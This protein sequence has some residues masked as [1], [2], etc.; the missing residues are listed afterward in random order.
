M[1]APENPD[2]IYTLE[3]KEAIELWKK[4]KD[5]WNKWV[6]ENPIAN[7]DFKHKEFTDAYI[8]FEGFNFPAGDIIFSK[9]IFQRKIKT[10]P[11]SHYI[12]ESNINNEYTEFFYDMF[13]TCWVNFKSCK[14]NDGSVY[15]DEAEFYNCIVIFEKSSFGKGN[16]SFRYSK[17]HKPNHKSLIIPKISNASIT[18]LNFD[19]TCFGEG[20]VDFTGSFFSLDEMTFNNSILSKGSLI[21]VDAIFHNQSNRFLNMDFGNSDVLFTRVKLKESNITFTSS[22]FNDGK[23]RFTPALVA[24]ER[25]SFEFCKFVGDGF[26]EISF[27]CVKKIKNISFYGSKIEKPI[28]I[29]KSNLIIPID[30]TNTHLTHHID[31]SKINFNFPKSIGFFFHKSKVQEKSN[32]YYDDM[33]RRLKMLAKESENY[34]LVLDFYAKEKRSDYGHN[35]KGWELFGYLLYDWLSNYGRSILR[36]FIGLFVNIILFSI[37]YYFF[38]EK[39]NKSYGDALIFSLSQTLS[40]Y[41]GSRQAKTD[42]IVSLYSTVEDMPNFVHVCSILEGVLSGIFIFLIILGLRNKFRS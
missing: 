37:P 35:I 10:I 34:K 17:F 30:F 38:S 40:I 20:E 41:S 9:T 25:I 32:R 14:F 12:S 6:E 22:K 7:V 16:I 39:I 33:F 24:S 8:S 27:P 29:E 1:N 15:F 26:I 42:T 5:A 2:K 21:F 19:N 4:G 3:G 23:F 18:N 13:D 11:I 36:P 28:S 31:F